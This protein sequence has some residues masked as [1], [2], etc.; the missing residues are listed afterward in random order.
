MTYTRLEPIGV[1]GQIIPCNFPLLMQAWKLGPALCAG[2]TIVMK[3]AEQTPLTALYVA[4]LI[5]E[6]GFPPG[7]VSI[8]PGYGPTAGAALAS[9]P[10]VRKIA[11][12]GS[13]EVG[14]A[15]MQA[16]GES[17]LKNVTLELGGKNPVIVLNY[18][19]IDLA[20]ETSHNAI[21]FNEGQ[22]CSA[23]SRTYV[24]ESIYDEFV[25]KSVSRTKA[26]KVMN[27]L[28]PDCEQGPQV[29]KE[30]LDKIMDLIEIGKKEGAT[31]AYGGERIGEKGYFVQ[32]TVFTEVQDDMCIAEE[33]IFGPV[34][35]IMKFKTIEEVIERSNNTKYG[36]AATVLTIET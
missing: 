6:A 9:H 11:F 8:I 19:D 36:L 26:R 35:Q 22:C 33:E 13:T 7:V 29:G 17:N 5:A 32:P 25:K 16:A 15:I 14:H 21:F 23:G 3:P 24:H 2:N 28:H 18:A 4:A 12:T 30:Q 1:V 20:I 34:M 10:N 27:P 31:L